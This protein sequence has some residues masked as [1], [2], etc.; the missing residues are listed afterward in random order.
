M[1]GKEFKSPSNGS[2][3][4]RFETQD[5]TA[6]VALPYLPDDF[7]GNPPSSQPPD[8]DTRQASLIEKQPSNIDAIRVASN[9]A[10]VATTTNNGGTSVE[11][12]VNWHAHRPDPSTKR[13]QSRKGNP[14]PPPRS[15]VININNNNII[16][17]QH[18]SPTIQSIQIYDNPSN[19]INNNYSIIGNSNNNSKWKEEYS[20]YMFKQGALNA[21]YKKRYFKLFSNKHIQYFDKENS[22]LKGTINLDC[23]LSLI[24]R[25][26]FM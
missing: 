20:G 19:D 25:S 13:R 11:T 18:Q 8:F 16:N 2:S 4:S 5:S 3:R 23:N 26:D 6:S 17:N 10:S 9:S 21:N 22:Q 7:Y 12:K 24:K 1:S 15:K 14:A